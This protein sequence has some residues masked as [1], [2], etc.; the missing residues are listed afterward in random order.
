[1]PV[2]ARW[3]LIHAT[4]ANDDEVR[5]LAASGAVVGL[6]PTTEASLGDGIFPATAYRSHGRPVRHRLG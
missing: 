4:H 3:C 1:M 2:D 5:L 6:C